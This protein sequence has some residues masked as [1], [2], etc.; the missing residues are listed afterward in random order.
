[1]EKN[2]VFAVIVISAILLFSQIL[3]VNAQDIPG[4]TITQGTPYNHNVDGVSTLEKLFNLINQNKFIITQTG[5][6]K[7]CDYVRSAYNSYLPGAGYSL[8]VTTSTCVSGHGQITVYRNSVDYPKLEFTDAAQFNCLDNGVSTDRCI[9]E[10][11]CCPHP[12]CSSNSNCVSWVGSGSTCTSRNYVYYDSF[13]KLPKYYDSTGGN[14]LTTYKACTASPSCTPETNAAFCTRLGKSCGSVTANDNCGVSRTYNCG[15]CSGG[16]TCSNGVCTG[17]TTSCIPN[18]DSRYCYTDASCC[19]GYCRDATSHCEAAP[20]D[21]NPTCTP[22]CTGKVCGDNGCSG[23]CGS[24]SGTQSCSNGQCV[25]SCPT[26]QTKCDDGVCRDNCDIVPT[27]CGDGVCSKGEQAYLEINKKNPDFCVAD[28][29]QDPPIKGFSITNVRLVDENGNY[30]SSNSTLQPGQMVT[31]KF[32]TKVK[33]SD[34]AARFCDSTAECLGKIWTGGL[35]YDSQKEYNIEAGIIPAQTAMKWFGSDINPTIFSLFGIDAPVTKESRCC[36]ADQPNILA[37]KTTFTNTL[38][39]KAYDVLVKDTG[40][41]AEEQHEITIQVPNKETEDMCPVDGES[42]SVYWDGSAAYYVL[43]IDI[44]NDCAY[45]NGVY[46]GNVNAIDKMYSLKL[47][48]NGTGVVSGYCDVNGDCGI[49]GNCVKCSDAISSCTWT[50][51]ITG[52]KR[53]DTAGLITTGKSLIDAKKF[54]LQKDVISGATSTELLA[55]SCLGSSECALLPKDT[56]DSGTAEARCI[57]IAKLRAEGV[58]TQADSDKFFSNAKTILKGTAGGAVAGALTCVIASSP[59]MSLGP[60]YILASPIILGSCAAIG[61]LIGGIVTDSYLEIADNDELVKQL[62]AANANAVG[63][64]TVEKGFDLNSWI[65]DLGKK[66]PITK[67]AFQDGLIILVGGIILF[68]IILN[69][70]MGKK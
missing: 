25:S 30:I 44:K 54:A 56:D 66:F 61:G 11:N 41:Y 5:I 64:C 32:T 68:M 24:C 58:L 15:I 2:K 10:I 43:Y 4:V 48:V 39:G 35:V 17:G 55:S 57:T 1:M 7:K 34:F 12:E 62:N 38:A 52:K 47:N 51:K 70:L 14:L 59:L 23:S 33:Y 46:K 3:I 21:T 16:K 50:D 13:S 63:I 29:P 49:N 28:C 27:D 65:T 20:D 60:G 67:N 18:G 8:A 40:S 22:S 42:P 69:I 19:S 6:D 26:G 9:V 37:D 45:K 36:E 31:V 53:C